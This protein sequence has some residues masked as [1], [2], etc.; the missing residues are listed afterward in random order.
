ML[1]F[2]RILCARALG[3]IMGASRAAVCVRL[4]NACCYLIHIARKSRN[5]CKSFVIPCTRDAQPEM[6]QHYKLLHV[7]CM[8]YTQNITPQS[9]R[10]IAAYKC[11]IALCLQFGQ[12]LSY[13]IWFFI[14]TLFPMLSA[15]DSPL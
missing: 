8:R 11:G 6:E 14:F 3:T 10:D 4:Q 12:F 15:P 5:H 7:R 1:R 2:A 13:V 9:A